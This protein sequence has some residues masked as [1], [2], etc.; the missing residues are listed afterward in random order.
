MGER[1][2][3]IFD[4]GFYY[5]LLLRQVRAHSLDSVSALDNVGLERDGARAAVELEEQA[6]GVAQNRAGLVAAP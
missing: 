3:N 4:L 1:G 5:L 2:V 6:A